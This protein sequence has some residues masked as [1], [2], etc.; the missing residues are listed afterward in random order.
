LHP[1]GRPA[2]LR[3]AHFSNLRTPTLFVSGTK[4]TFGSIAEL[5]GAI[6]L[7]HG[8]TKLVAIEGA[9]HGLSQKSKSGEVP[10]V[11]VQEFRSFFSL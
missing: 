5:E 4:D 6:K 9:P 2:Q 10:E 3:T 7:I 1:P 8:R 11:V